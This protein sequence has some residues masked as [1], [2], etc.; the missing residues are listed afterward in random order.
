MNYLIIG[1]SFIKGTGAQNNLGWAQMF[2]NNNPQL[3]VEISGV[4]GDN[5]LKVNN[6]LSSLDKDMFDIVIL[7]VGINDSRYR[8][9]KNGYEISL[10]NFQDGLISFA[11]YFTERNSKVSIF[12]TG[13]T[14]VDETKTSPYKHDKYYLNKNIEIFDRKLQE[15]SSMIGVSYIYVP[16]LIDNLNNLSDGLHPSNQ[17]HKILL[18]A[19]TQKVY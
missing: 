4:G 10:D 6:R 1:D 3:N 9:S 19:V 18:D 13:L 17:G 16:E 5:I 14:K 12:F 15:T 2:K 7:G 11:N 8:P